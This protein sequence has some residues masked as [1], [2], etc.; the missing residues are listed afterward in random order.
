MKFVM[1]GSFLWLAT[2]IPTAAET[3]YCMLGGDAYGN[4]V[5]VSGLKCDNGAW[6]KI[7]DDT[8]NCLYAGALYSQGAKVSVGNDVIICNTHGYWN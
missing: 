2:I 8:A 7:R 6:N 3:N 1:I 4:D 5:R